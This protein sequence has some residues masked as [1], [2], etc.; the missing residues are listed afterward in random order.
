MQRSKFA[1]RLFL[2]AFLFAGLLQQPASS[3]VIDY[4]IEDQGRIIQQQAEFNSERVV[5]QAA[6]GDPNQDLLFDTRQ[7]ILLVIDHRDRSYLQIDER[8]INEVAA[9]METVSGAV[10]NQ[11]GVLADLMNTLGL[12]NGE[13]E[14]PAAKLHDTGQQLSIAGLQCQL[15]QSHREGTLQ[16]EV[17]VAENDQLG[18]VDGE[19]NALRDFLGFG[20]LMLNKAGPLIEALGLS[21]P[22]MDLANRPGL[23]IG[24]H[25]A[26]RNLKVRLTSI[27][28]G[29]GAGNYQLPAGYSRSAIPFTSG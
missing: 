18:L 23:P 29:G 7:N 17:C 25:S 11:Q 8:V 4:V 21:L 26:T 1:T 15:Y 2:V 10:E 6:G 13:S 20:N 24:M 3:A 16:S 28:P 19:Y 9:L 27:A 14:P 22:Q 12:Q 5:V